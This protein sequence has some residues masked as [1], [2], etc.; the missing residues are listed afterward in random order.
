M[1]TGKRTILGI[2]EGNFAVSHDRKSI[3]K[4]DNAKLGL[5][6]RELLKLGNILKAE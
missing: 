5:L 1:G 2:A 4:A 3:A 6:I